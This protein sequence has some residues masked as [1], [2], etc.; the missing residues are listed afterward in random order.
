[1]AAPAGEKVLVLQS[2][3]PPPR[4]EWRR[5]C[6]AS[7]EGWA[8]GQGYAY[9]LIGD[10]LFDPIPDELERACVGVLLPLTDIGRLLWLQKL[11]R[12]GWDRV[13]WLDADILIFDPSLRLTGE[14]VGRE[15]W[16][17]KGRETGYRA[18]ESVNNCV[19]SV[20]AQSPLRQRLLEATLAEAASF[21]AAPHPRAL[22]PDLFR[23]LHAAD[24]LPVAPDIAMASPIMLAALAGGDPAPLAA[25]RAVWVGPVRAANLCGSLMEGDE[26][27]NRAVRRLLEAPNALSPA[28][29]SPPVEWIRFA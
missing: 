7:V 26:Q 13:I 16:I 25:H 11:L 15:I 8:A 17:S 6:L 29:A 1:M 28:M 18:A 19:L 10:E 9:R 2:D 3:R 4:P 23:R 27:A 22:G 21:R 5:R 14:A 12:E 24:P 20:A